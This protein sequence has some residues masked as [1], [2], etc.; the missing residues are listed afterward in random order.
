MYVCTQSFSLFNFHV[1]ETILVANVFFNRAV[2]H[3]M[4]WWPSFIESR[5]STT[6]NSVVNNCDFPFPWSSFDHICFGARRRLGFHRRQAPIWRPPWPQLAHYTRI[7]V[8]TYYT[9]LCSCRYVYT[10][11]CPASVGY[12]LCG[13]C[14]RRYVLLWGRFCF[15]LEVVRWRGLFVVYDIVC[16]CNGM[17]CCILF[18]VCM[19]FPKP[20]WFGGGVWLL[21]IYSS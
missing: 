11:V 13:R 1:L 5:L 17:W 6:V 20:G 15:R 14:V 9:S 4:F 21:K 2:R 19:Y 3:R 8:C 12:S 18:N 16:T 10:Y 7:Y